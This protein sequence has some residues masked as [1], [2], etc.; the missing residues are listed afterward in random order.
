ML[1]VNFTELSRILVLLFLASS[2]C[3]E[4]EEQGAPP[5]PMPLVQTFDC[6]GPVL[7]PRTQVGSST[8]VSIQCTVSNGLAGQN[9]QIKNLSTDT[10]FEARKI[11]SADS[12]VTG[13][14]LELAVKYE[15]IVATENDKGIIIIEYVTA[16][17]DKNASI[18][19]NAS[20]W[21]YNNWDETIALVP[22]SVT[23]N[24]PLLDQALADVMLTQETFGFS[25]Q[26]FAESP[27]EGAGLLNDSFLLSWFRPTRARPARIGCFEGEMVGTI[28]Q[29]MKGK[30][31]VAGVIRHLA[32]KL[33]SPP[34]GA[35]PF[36]T[37][38]L[39]GDG[40]RAIDAICEEFG[41][42]CFGRQGNIPDDLLE[43]ITPLLWSIHE[44]VKVRLA[45]DIEA[46]PVNPGWWTDYGSNLL[47]LTN[48][49]Q[50][51]DP[52]NP[53]QREYLSTEQRSKLYRA[54]SQ[55]AYAVQDIDWTPFVGRTDIQFD[56]QT[57]AGWIRV[58]DSKKTRYEASE[59]PV[60]LLIDLGGDDEYLNE[61]ASNRTGDNMVSLA[62]DLEGE[63]VY[64]YDKQETPF[65]RDGLPAADN[66]GR[67]G[68]SP[69]NNLGNITLSN[70][71]RQGSAR[72]GIAMLF[73]L[74]TADDVYESLVASQGY[75]HLGVG[76]LFDEGGNDKY[77]SEALS[78]GAAQFGIGI[79]ID[80]G[81]GWDERSSFTY[82]QGFAF[83]GAAGLTWDGGGD[84]KYI[85]NHG[86][87]DRG[88]I[89]LYPSA[90]LPDNGNS[91]FCQGAGFGRR[92]Q[93][94]S[95]NDY[96]SGG[97]GILRDVDGNDEYEA[98]VF[99][100]GTGY[101]QGTGL[102]SDGGGSDKYDAYW[103]VQGAAAHYAI[104]I[105]ADAGDG[106]DLFNTERDT[107][108]MSM[109][110]GH[111]YSLG[112]LINEKGDNEY[113]LTTL[114][115]GSSN[116]NGIGLF[117]DNAGND[118]Y[119]AT[120]DKNSGMGNVSTECIMER[121]NAVSIG[122]MLDAGGTD[123]YNY[124]MSMFDIPMDNSTWGH[125]RNGLE[126]EYGSGLDTEGET[127]VHVESRNLK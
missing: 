31:A 91:S 74:G 101:W 102:L 63:D 81:D 68:G 51:P 28:D 87:P 114:A 89:R 26:D 104:G 36:D 61:V 64:S 15:P 54:A 105:H 12:I 108:N 19:I 24:A 53:A 98:S 50:R 94:S 14:S 58:R 45:M 126:S 66:S 40:E 119:T 72:N 39:P 57:P 29:L 79:S 93:S 8:E 96:M 80:Q 59:D 82:S 77:R 118:S 109:G 5:A 107:R 113:K 100:Q 37:R 7:I 78:Q 35:R 110:S 73:D 9:L 4:S 46:A 103:Y 69:D 33:D 27:Y 16:G 97:I 52:T 65:D 18:E 1:N 123:R 95:V 90:Q 13:S 43:A 71:F 86:D 67:Y 22:C 34:D 83:A 11:T 88:G 32:T 62:I 124:P 17:Q 99:A 117:V 76:V 2:G 115:A 42:A 30:H 121:P 41:S 47:L 112:V 48:G 3:G 70:R 6:G 122:I 56:Q 120:S 21:D 92:A 75:S 106:N 20:S 127:G 116:C 44:A 125:Q 10:P 85:C 38:N 25:Q 55:I 60:L 23:E 111:D 49:N 84:D